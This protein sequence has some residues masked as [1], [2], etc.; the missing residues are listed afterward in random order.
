MADYEGAQRAHVIPV[1]N[2]NLGTRNG[3]CGGDGDDGWIIAREMGMV[4]IQIAHFDLVMGVA[5]VAFD[6]D[7]ITGR[8]LV[9]DVIKARFGFSRNSWMMAQRPFETTATS[10][11]PAL[12][13][14]KL[15]RPSWSMSKE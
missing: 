12:R 7:E 11:A 2:R 15:S 4:E 13:W 9:Q 14:R 1:K 10:V 3:T 8:Q 5:L 6:D